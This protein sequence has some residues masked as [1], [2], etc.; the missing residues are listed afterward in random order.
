MKNILNRILYI[1]VLCASSMF[2]LNKPV[3]SQIRFAM[4]DVTIDL[5]KY[6]TVE[7]CMTLRNRLNGRE[8]RRL[9]YWK[10]SLEYTTSD[11][12][13]PQPD[14]VRNTLTMCMSKFSTANVDYSNYSEYLDWIRVFYDVG[15]NDDAKAVIDKKLSTT[16]WDK[17]DT[18]GRHTVITALL[19]PLGISRPIPWDVLV[20]VAR[21]IDEPDASS[22]WETRMTIYGAMM[23][24]AKDVNDTTIQ[25]YS[26]EKAIELERTLTEKDKLSRY[27]QA[28]GRYTMLAAMDFV[29]GV[30]ML[31]SLRVSS[32]SYVSFRNSYWKKIRGQNSDN[33]PNHV[34]ETAKPIL[35]DFWFQRQADTVVRLPQAPGTIP[36]KGSI[37]LI[38]FL[39]MRCEENTPRFVDQY[40]RTYPSSGLCMPS[41]SVI[42]RLAERYPALRVTIVSMTDGFIGLT[43]PLSPEQ[44]AIHK[45]QWWLNTFRLPATLAVS[46]Q[47]F[48]QLPAPDGRR[49]DEIH[50]NSTNYLFNGANT[51]VASG[52]GF[53]VDVDGTVLFSSGMS[54]NAERQF[55]LLLNVITNRK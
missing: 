55:N 33:L 25:R 54:I 28:N 36:A 11:R 39:E 34:G 47:K 18:A 10:D 7:E 43:E 16:K 23:T 29:H 37:N 32:N 38:V 46:E 35:G 1:A 20:R 8:K 17:E 15:R 12:I 21:M 30:A 13:H 31:D 52:T 6:T 22:P 26:A 49:V 41:Y 14:P 42:R 3:E 51:R 50:E 9:T 45:S 5:S 2:L 40:H 27:W 4:P 24:L 44:E 48:F 53:L 19:G